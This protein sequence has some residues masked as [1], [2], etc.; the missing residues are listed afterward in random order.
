VSIYILELKSDLTPRRTAKLGENHCCYKKIVCARTAEIA[1]SIAARDS[2][3]MGEFDN[4]RI[5]L[6]PG[7]STCK[8]ID[9]QNRS[10][11][12]AAEYAH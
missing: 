10:E 1:R 2:A 9:M 7:Y 8:R 5:W 4:P 3:G 12:L 11:V 6:Q